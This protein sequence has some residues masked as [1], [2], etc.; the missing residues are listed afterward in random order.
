MNNSNFSLKVSDVEEYM[1]PSVAYKLATDSAVYRPSELMF[2]S[3]LASYILGFIGLILSRVGLIDPSPSDPSGF[4]IL[5]LYAV[6]YVA[7]SIAFAYLTAGFYLTYHAGILTMHHMPL[8]NLRSD[9]LLALLQALSFGISMLAPIL[10]PIVVGLIL[11]LAYLRQVREHRRHTK[12]F[13]E[14]LKGCLKGQLSAGGPPPDQTTA[15]KSERR[16][17]S[18]EEKREKRAAKKIAKQKEKLEQA[19]YTAFR[20]KFVTLVETKTELSVWKPMGERVL[21]AAGLFIAISLGL[22]I[23]YFNGLYD[24]NILIT[25]TNRLIPLTLILTAAS[26]VLV[27]IPIFI[28]VRRILKDRA[29]FL[30]KRDIPS[31]IDM[32]C[33]FATLLADLKDYWSTKVA[34]KKSTSEQS[35]ANPSQFKKDY[36]ASIACLGGLWL[37][38]AASGSRQGANA[39][40]IG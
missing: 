39:Q 31:A 2:G 3:L 12:D 25:S 9:F 28:K 6:Q 30:Y 17:I 14:D 4:Y 36:D 1:L 26:S 13:F 18:L 27:S 33:E 35:S 16:N 11:L 20:K 21:F 5:V 38:E 8:E 32:N 40:Q 24:L 10:F 37:K 19:A 29:M 34:A 7:I 23:W 22:S 15:K